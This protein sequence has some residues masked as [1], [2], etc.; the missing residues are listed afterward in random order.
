MRLS[1]RRTLYASY[2]IETF[3]AIAG[4]CL[5]HE[6]NKNAIITVDVREMFIKSMS[7]QRCSS[8]YEAPK[9]SI[10]IQCQSIVWC[11]L[12]SL[13]G[14]KHFTEALFRSTNKTRNND[15]DNNV[16]SHFI[17]ITWTISTLFHS[18]AT[19]GKSK[20]LFIGVKTAHGTILKQYCGIV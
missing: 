8:V 10:K 20:A 18:W 16:S 17:L 3:N 15:D 11:N 19:V 7:G 14:R 6:L 2:W 9:I 1:V 12:N 4:Y 5:T 13:S